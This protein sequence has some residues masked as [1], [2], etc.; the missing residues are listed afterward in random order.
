MLFFS[1]G[2]QVKRHYGL[3]LK[4]GR[5]R[6]RVREPLRGRIVLRRARVY[7]AAVAAGV[8]APSVRRVI[9]ER[10]GGSAGVRVMNLAHDVVELAG[11]LFQFADLETVVCHM[12]K[13]GEILAAGVS[14]LLLR[15]LGEKLCHQLAS[16]R[17]LL[18]RDDL[19]EKAANLLLGYRTQCAA[20]YT[21]QPEYEPPN[22]SHITP[23]SVARIA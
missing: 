15:T 19:T 5:A 7:W 13:E 12:A 2:L 3:F 8:R 11:N 21:A 10:R 9:Y 16:S 14:I 20:A 4:S 18:I 6:T 1:A 17:S 23:R 22:Q